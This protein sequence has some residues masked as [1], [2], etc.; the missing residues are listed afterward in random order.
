[1]VPYTE[2]KGLYIGG[3]WV[4]PQ[5]GEAEAVL[6]PATEE[7][8]GMAP[9]GGPEEIELA[10]VAARQAFDQGPWPRLSMAERIK[11]VEAFLANLE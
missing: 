10:L 2:N 1:M 8:I 9:L 4:W 7:I 3:E 6:N 11:K 5:S